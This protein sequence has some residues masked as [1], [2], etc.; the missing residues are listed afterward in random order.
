MRLLDTE[1]GWFVEKDPETTEYAILS[2]TWDTKEGEQTY[3]ELKKIQ[4]RCGPASHAPQS[5]LDT[6]N[7]VSD[8][9]GPSSTAPPS[10]LLRAPSVATSAPASF[11]LSTPQTQPDARCAYVCMPVAAPSSNDLAPSTTSAPPT[12]LPAPWDPS[13]PFLGLQSPASQ[14]SIWD[15]PELSPKI[16]DA[17]AVARKEGY[18]YIWIDSCC[19]DKSSSSEL[20]EAINSMYS[21]YARAAVCYAYLAD[22]PPGEDHQ[23]GGSFFRT[24]RWFTR[25][26]TLQE[27][28]APISVEF[29][30]ADWG[31]IGSKHALVD[32]VE[33]VT[34]IN[35][36]A[37]LHIVPLERFCIAQRLSWAANRKTTRKED[38]AYCLLGIFD[39]HMPT[40]YGE[41]NHAFQRLQEQVMQRIPDQ[42]LFAWGQLYL[43]SRL[44]KNIDHWHTITGVG[45]FSPTPR[46]DTTQ[47]PSSHRWEVEYTSTPYG[48]RTQFHMFPLTRDSLLGAMPR[49]KNVQLVPSSIWKDCRL[50]LAVLAA[51]LLR[52]PPSDTHLDAEFVYAACIEVNV[53]GKNPCWPDLFPLSPQTLERCRPHTE[54]KTVYFSH[55]NR[56]PL[57]LKSHLPHGAIKLVLLRETR[58]ALRSRRGYSADLRGP[59][60]LDSD[61]ATHRL[62]LSKDEHAITIEFRHTLENGGERFTIEAQSTLDRSDQLEAEHCTV[63]WQDAVPWSAGLRHHTVSLSVPGSQTLTVDVG[64]DFAG[65]GFYSIEVDVLSDIEPVSSESRV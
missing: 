27:L 37:L 30:S 54:L 61:H 7:S 1:T 50:Y 8:R 59:S 39:I 15:D 36:K 45:I 60:L 25:G 12:D 51:C 23:A 17:C 48:I 24:S 31:F 18:R 47:L 29:L 53:K 20:S 65:T 19:I 3:K 33:S 40:L 16:R 34:R 52:P 28:I 56:A 43:D 55:P 11:R 62:I 14:P 5:D 57:H 2:H 49:F 32:L 64:L 13:A 41:G 35:S 63:F 26:W 21:W 9:G 6:S 38:R 10:Q 42:S 58:D 44:F 46:R 4:R 22:V